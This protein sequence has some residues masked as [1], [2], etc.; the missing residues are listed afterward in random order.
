VE[1][2]KIRNGDQHQIE[3]IYNN[4]RSEFISWIVKLYHCSLKDAGDIY[5]HAVLAFYENVISNKLKVLECSV[6]TYLFAIGRKKYLE[7]LKSEKKFLKI[8]HERTLVNLPEVQKTDA[9]IKEQQLEC[10]EKGLDK[11]GEPGRTILELYYYHGKSMEEIAQLLHY[12]NSATAKNL[13]YKCLL[14]LRKI[15][16]EEHKK[17]TESKYYE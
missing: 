1:L 4:H 6:K 13:K 10:V 9:L 11:L 14:R 7:L 15:C 8:D 17:V 12:K 2:D 16:E 5:H 3:T